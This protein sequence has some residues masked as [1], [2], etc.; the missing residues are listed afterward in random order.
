MVATNDFKI[1]GSN[2]VVVKMAESETMSVDTSLGNPDEH[3][4]D[5]SDEQ[6]A[7]L[8]ADTT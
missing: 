5:L 7:Q 3:I 8:V 4:V 6:L 1:F 2:S